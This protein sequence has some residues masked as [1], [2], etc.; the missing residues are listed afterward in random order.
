MKKILVVD[1]LPQGC[2]GSNFFTGGVER[3]NY[4]LCKVLG[5]M[6]HEVHTVQTLHGGRSPEECSYG[7]P[8]VTQHFIGSCYRMDPSLTDP[9]ERRN[10]TSDWG[11]STYR[12][13]G[14]AVRSLGSIDFAFNNTRGRY[15]R[16]LCEQGIPTLQPT[17]CS[18]TQQGG[19]PGSVNKWL[20]APKFFP[21]E[22]FRFGWIS[23]FVKRDYMRYAEKHLGYEI[24]EE[25]MAEHIEAL[26]EFEG[27]V[28]PEGE[29][30][31]VIS[32]CSPDKHPHVALDLAT[33][34][35]KEVHFYTVVQD[36][37][38]YRERI[39]RYESHPG[40]RIF[41]DRPHDEILESLRSSRG[42][43]MTAR[44]ETFGIVGVEALERGVP[45]LY[46]STGAHLGEV[47]DIAPQDALVAPSL[48]E[49]VV[50]SA[51][52]RALGERIRS[53]SLSLAQRRRIA[54][55]TRRHFGAARWRQN[56]RKLI[57]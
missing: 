46:A 37:R 30:F 2:A 27:E 25:Y 35:G 29:H 14:E 53:L 7:L 10:Y 39:Q 51:D 5:E 28:L 36:E 4:T 6:G 23:E 20:Q 24:G 9:L 40:V 32:R 56:L 16:F 57:G 38:Y 17:H 49:T 13:F 21:P 34:A 8:N 48:R 22:L 41:V 26:S 31:T 43:I 54:R 42:L 11:R 19:L 3:H 18:T 44:K 45:V 55:E 12:K 33:A 15:S 50:R 1:A 52:R 47:L